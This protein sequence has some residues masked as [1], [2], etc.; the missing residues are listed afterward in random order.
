MRYLLMILLAIGCEPIYAFSAHDAWDLSKKSMESKC[1]GKLAPVFI[2]IQAEASKG[3]YSL[4][5]K[6]GEISGCRGVLK[7]MGYRVNTYSNISY[8]AAEIRWD[9]KVSDII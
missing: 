4:A 9:S 2:K 5:V 7:N 8:E 6:N 3:E 1:A